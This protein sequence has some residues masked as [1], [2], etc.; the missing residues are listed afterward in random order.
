LKNIFIGFLLLCSTITWAQ[1]NDFQDITAFGITYGDDFTDWSLYGD[2]E[3]PEGNL[4]IRWPYQNDWT[5]WDFRYGDITG[6]IK[7]RNKSDVR[8]WELRSGGKVLTMKAIYPDDFNQW[9][10][11]DDS[12]T[13]NFQTK[14]TNLYDGW[15][16]SASKSGSFNVYT[17]WEMD[18]RDWIIQD[19]SNDKVTFPFKMA[20]IFIASYYS[21]PKY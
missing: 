8:I 12:Y 6:Q 17:Q 9:R 16:M 7:L 19:K 14:Y 4:K 20:M 11:T 5:E 15:E 21:S 18:P 2:D 10:I 13:I 3:Q 1:Q